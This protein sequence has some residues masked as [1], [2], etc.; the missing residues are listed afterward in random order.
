MLLGLTWVVTL[1]CLRGLTARHGVFLRTPKQSE[2]PR[3]AEIVRVVWFEDFWHISLL[4]V[5]WSS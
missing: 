2:Q 1:A 5:A 4:P 3:L